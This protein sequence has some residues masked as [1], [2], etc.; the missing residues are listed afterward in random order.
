[1]TS[2]T[3]IEQAPVPSEPVI[4]DMTAGARRIAEQIN[5]QHW[6]ARDKFAEHAVECGRLLLAQKERVGYGNFGKWIEAN[7]DF[8]VATANNYMRVAKNPSALGKSGAIRRL[9]PSGFADAPK[10][11]ISSKPSETKK[12]K[13]AVVVMET[14]VTKP[15]V[16]ADPVPMREAIKQLSSDQQYELLVEAWNRASESERIQFV[17]R[18]QPQ[19]ETLVPIA[20]DTKDVTFK[21]EIDEALQTQLSDELSAS[22]EYRGFVSIVATETKDA[23]EMTAD[24]AI[25]ILK[26][27]TL[28]GTDNF[29]E[30][31]FQVRHWRSQVTKYRN[32][33]AKAE[34]DLALA[35]AAMIKAA[36]EIQA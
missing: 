25:K 7:C 24:E 16:T 20:E 14:N 33:L 17:R 31:L 21:V 22:G 10:K 23:A 2:V 12:T 3:S 8:S 9:Y 29:S 32:Q 6:L 1:M 19:H 34:K 5:E 28:D 36:M 27:L 15:V 26:S 13:P 35:E 4:A 18:V 30:I 11:I